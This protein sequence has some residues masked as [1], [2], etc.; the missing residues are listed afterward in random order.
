MTASVL[1]G[2][3]FPCHR[4]QNLYNARI[5]GSRPGAE[6]TVS[7]IS[8]IRWFWCGRASRSVVPCSRLL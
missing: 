5:R 1:S 6:R 7:A 3:T 2:A 4:G 8:P